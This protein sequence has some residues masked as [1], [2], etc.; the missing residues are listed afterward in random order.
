MVVNFAYKKYIL[1]LK[2]EKKKNKEVLT[3]FSD[4]FSGATKLI[5]SLCP[6]IDI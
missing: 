2:K 3:M 5:Q 6:C 1:I 4:I